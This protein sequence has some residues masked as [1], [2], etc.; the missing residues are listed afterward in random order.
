MTVGLHYLDFALAFLLQYKPSVFIAFFGKYA[1]MR[2]GT[3]FSPAV[4][5][6]PWS[7]WFPQWPAVIVRLLGAAP[8]LSSMHRPADAT[9]GVES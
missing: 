6:L 1:L 3:V 9:G 8:F 2:I 5:F 7:V 4:P